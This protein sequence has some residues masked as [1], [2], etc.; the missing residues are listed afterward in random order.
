MTQDAT[1]QLVSGPGDCEAAKAGS[2]A[3]R[4]ASFMSAPAENARSP[5]PV[6]TIAIT[7]GSASISARASSISRYMPLLIALRTSG[8]FKVT[9]PTPSAFS[10]M[11]FS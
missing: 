7:A 2:D 10:T 11:M 4:A 1:C 9:V 8:R 3:I 5:I 6:K